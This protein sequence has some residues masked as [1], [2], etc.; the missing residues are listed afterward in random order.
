[1][2]EGESQED[3][4]GL[5]LLKEQHDDS[6]ED[7]GELTGIDQDVYG[8]T[9]FSVIYDLSELFTGADTDRLGLNLHMMRMTFVLLILTAN[10]SL[11]VG[12]L[13]WVY[14]YIVL[15]TVHQAQYLYQMYHHDC[16]VDGVFSLELFEKWPYQTELCGIG[17]ANFGFMYAI[18]FL[19]W[20]TM[21]NELRKNDRMLRTIQSVSHTDDPLQMVFVTDDGAVHFKKLMKP[22][23]WILY[24][25]L[26]VPKILITVGLLLVGT[27]WLTA[28]ARYEDIIMN[29]IAL[30]FVVQV[31]ELLFSAMLPTFICA[32]I[33]NTKFWK[34]VP[35]GDPLERKRTVFVRG[36]TRSYVYLFGTVTLVYIFLTYGQELPLI[37]VFPGFEN[38]VYCDEVFKKTYQRVCVFGIECF[39]KG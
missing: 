6:N 19:W 35:E 24:I 36:Y 7:A 9:L 30:E 2:S 8:A 25:V 27:V 20:M 11:Q 13:Y 34:P 37:G 22:V 1:M 18:L 26:V 16:F 29:A 14:T 28:T 38:D 21:V 15:T 32:R 23:R 33:A 4:S 5:E 12:M 3:N 31:D 17:F 39:T 10:F